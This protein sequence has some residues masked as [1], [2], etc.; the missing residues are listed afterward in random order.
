MTREERNSGIVAVLRVFT[1]LPY[2]IVY[3]FLSLGFSMVGVDK[4]SQ[5]NEQ[6]HE[7]TLTLCSLF[8]TAA[9]VIFTVATL[10]AGYFSMLGLV[11]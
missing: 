2:K 7:L 6:L 5:A 8:V 11:G 3:G 9:C 4:D 10:A 1:W